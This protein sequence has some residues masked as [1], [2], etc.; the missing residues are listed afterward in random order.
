MLGTAIEQFFVFIQTQELSLRCALARVF[1]GSM[2][3]GRPFA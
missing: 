1:D 2:R 3:H